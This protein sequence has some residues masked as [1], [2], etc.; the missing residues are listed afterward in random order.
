[1]FDGFTREAIKTGAV[2]INTVYGGKGPPILLL[3]GFPQTHVMWHKVAPALVRHFTVVATDLRGYGD[4]DKPPGG[5]D[6]AAYSKRVMA[7]DQVD[8]MARLGF[9]RFAVVGHD[10]GGRVAHRLAL[11]HPDRVAKLVVVDIAPT[12]K[13]YEAM[14]ARLAQGYWHWFFLALPPGIPE[15]IIGKSADYFMTQFFRLAPAGTFT[16]AAQAEYRR[17]FPAMLPGGCE[18]FRAGGSIDLQHDRGD[19]GRN[20]T[21]PV[22]AL[23]G[24]TG[25]VVPFFDALEVWRERAARVEGRAL[26]GGHS[27]AEENPDDTLDALRAFLA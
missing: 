5:G 6:H 9:E 25:N 8:V 10:R 27:L 23:W 20:V 11:D 16:P 12:L 24:M 22:L 19:R 7:Q 21:C 14:D 26:P 1:M 15:T 3:H 13:V 2:T 18:D 4:S 17:C